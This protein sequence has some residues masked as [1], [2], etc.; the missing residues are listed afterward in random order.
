MNDLV[1][2]AV[3]VLEMLELFAV[4]EESLGVSDVARRMEIPK[5]SAQAL[6]MTLT[7]QGYLSKDSLGYFLPT[8]LRGGWVGGIRNRLISIASPIL[9]AMADD[10]QESAFIGVLTT[11]AKIQYLA[12]AISQNEVRYDASL[13]HLRPIHCTSMGLVIMAYSSDR[14]VAQWLKPSHIKAITSH[15]ETNVEKIYTAIRRARKDGYAEIKNGNIEGASGVSA[16]VFG[17]S[18]Q[19]IAA[20]NLGAPTWRYEQYREKLIQIVCRQA[21]VVTASLSKA[22]KP[23]EVL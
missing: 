15:T 19:I 1:K 2:S 21:K 10:S 20:L 14:D 22:D 7:A 18:G 12:K 17:P 16:P 9:Q 4:V 8:Q 13:E 23:M 3:R 6:L 11:G 5:S